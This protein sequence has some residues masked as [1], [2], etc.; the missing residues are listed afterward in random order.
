MGLVAWGEF[1]VAFALF[2]VSHA[3]PARPPV[4]RRLVGSLGERGY[5]AAYGAVSLAILAWLVTAAGRAP[6]VPLWPYSEGLVWIANIVMPLACLLVSCGIRA[7]NP[8]SFGGT[9]R[10]FDPQH[11]GI[12]GITRHPLLLALAC[13]AGVHA[14]VNGDFSH[15]LLFGGFAIFALIGMRVLDGRKRRQFGAARW[16]RLAAK[17]SGLP[18]AALITGRWRPRLDQVAALRI[19]LGLLLWV[20]LLA[21]HPT[22]IGVTPL[23]PA[24]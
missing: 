9:S 12:A 17:T 6:Y 4:R 5:L 7:P 19:M 23:P 10:G 22:T 20:A 15:V 18:I 8:F 11:P 24:P 21:L 16:Q 2:L 1:G 13:W 3:L 14:L